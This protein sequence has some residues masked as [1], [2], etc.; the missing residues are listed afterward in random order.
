MCRSLLL[1]AAFVLLAG[2]SKSVVAERDSYLRAYHNG[3]IT[4]AEH[5]LS[6][7]IRKELPQK[8]YILS[9]EAGWLLLDRA[10][11]R[12]AEDFT[13][14][15]VEDFAIALQA[16]D[17][18][19]K[20]LPIDQANRLL[21]QDDASVY[22]ASDYEQVLTCVYMSLV[23][24]HRGDEGNA[25]ALLRRIEDYQQEKMAFYANVP[26]TRDYQMEQN[27]LSKYLF[28]LLLEKKG[29]L[30]NAKILYQQAAEL[31]PSSCEGSFEPSSSPT[32]AKVIVICHNGNVPY[33]ISTTAPAS[34]A[35]A[36]ALE[37]ILAQYGIRPSCSTLPG[38]PIP[39]LRRGAGSYPLPTFATLDGCEKPLLPYYSV[40]KAARE[41]LEQKMPPHYRQRSRTSHPQKGCCR[42]F[43]E[44]KCRY[45]SYSRLYDVDRQCKH[46]C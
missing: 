12:F 34:Q 28:A 26:L 38:I 41:E 6:D 36:L 31:I 45:R 44:A 9:K 39:E 43:G 14:G 35:S 7:I 16:I 24:F 27:G 2:C 22:Q 40:A 19:K 32:Q 17:Y 23:L 5:E 13:E 10:T 46:H 18:Y 33:K 11:V 25:L 42:L 4:K 15:A 20:D 21:L 30:S 37:I 8:S 1:L 3:D 29:D